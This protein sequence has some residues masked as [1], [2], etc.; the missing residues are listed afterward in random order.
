MNSAGQLGKT[1]FMSSMGL[2]LQIVPA[3]AWIFLMRKMKDADTTGIWWT[4][5]RTCSFHSHQRSSLCRQAVLL[6]RKMVK[7]AGRKSLLRIKSGKEN[8]FLPLKGRKIK[9]KVVWSGN[10]DQILTSANSDCGDNQ[11]VEIVSSGLSQNTSHV[12]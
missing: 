2:A 1:G 12:E 4:P 10:R 6:W 9:G 3:K 11:R 5:T 7:V 8:I